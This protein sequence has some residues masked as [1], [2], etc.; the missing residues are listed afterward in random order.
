MTE[1]EIL[2]A[3]DGEFGFDAVHAYRR[4]Q[5]LAKEIVN[6]MVI[7]GD[8]GISARDVYLTVSETTSSS[9]TRRITDIE[10]AGFEVYRERCMNPITGKCYTKYFLD[11]FVAPSRMGISHYNFHMLN[12]GL[13]RAVQG[14]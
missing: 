13:Q 2:A 3:I 5:P 1:Y 6:L 7:A 8:D 14:L 9:F 4:L 10:K 11:D 12:E